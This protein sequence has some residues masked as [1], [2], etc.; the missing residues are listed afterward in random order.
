MWKLVV[1]IVHIFRSFPV[2]FVTFILC[3]DTLQW[4]HAKTGRIETLAPTVSAST[5]LHGLDMH[6]QT[7]QSCERKMNGLPKFT[8]L[9][10]TSVNEEE[11]EP[12]SG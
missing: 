11:M 10:T 9:D 6:S 2:Q 4:A 12:L 5:G 8:L 7:P 1:L 3:V